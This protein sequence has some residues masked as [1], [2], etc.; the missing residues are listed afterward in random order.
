MPTFTV[1]DDCRTALARLF[2]V[3]Q[4]HQLRFG[5]SGQSLVAADHG[6][7]LNG[8]VRFRDYIMEGFLTYTVHAEDLTPGCLL[9]V[10]GEGSNRDWSIRPQVRHYIKAAGLIIRS[11]DD[12]EPSD[13]AVSP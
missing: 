5:W 13:A 3:R 2:E 6:D 11:E 9:R 10:T 4:G 1:E 7:L 8:S 12:A